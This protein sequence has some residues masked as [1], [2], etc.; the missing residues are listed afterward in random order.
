MN[1]DEAIKILKNAVKFTGTID[2]KHIDLTV[3]PASER[4]TYEKALM[5]SQTSIKA[6]I[7]TREDF[8]RRVNLDS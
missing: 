7:I 3:V 5:V 4:A 2:Q 1:L 8:L 6:G